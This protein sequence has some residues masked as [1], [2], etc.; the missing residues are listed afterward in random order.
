MT[1]EEF[2]DDPKIIEE[3][4]DKAEENDYWQNV[5]EFTLSN[6]RVDLDA[7]T[8]KQINWLYKIKE[9]LCKY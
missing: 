9:D 7:L 2:F 1:V 3:L 5:L 8:E 6:F 4:G